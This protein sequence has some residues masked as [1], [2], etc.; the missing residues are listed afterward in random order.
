MKPHVLEY[1]H[2]KLW[3]GVG[4]LKRPEGVI[5]LNAIA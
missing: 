1:Y 4:V 2:F 3:L 5:S